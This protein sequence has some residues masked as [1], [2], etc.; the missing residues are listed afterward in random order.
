MKDPSRKF[1]LQLSL[2]W[3]QPLEYIENLPESVLTEYMALNALS[4]FTHDAAAYREGLTATILYNNNATK[5]SEAKSVSDLF[6]YLSTETP[7]WLE[8]IRIKKAKSILASIQCHNIGD[9]AN[10][11][12][13]YNHIC[14]KIR[15]EIQ[16]ESNKNNPDMYV[17]DKL[18]Q[19]IGD[20]DGRK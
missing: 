9:S 16:M 2:I 6:P 10:Y 12:N 7:D 14:G 3:G 1:Q 8:D 5:K 15:E 17:I 20:A 4:P 11:T 13:N 19:L 18:T